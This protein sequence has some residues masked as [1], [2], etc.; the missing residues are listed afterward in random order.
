MGVVDYRSSVSQ[1]VSLSQPSLNQITVVL[2]VPTSKI[3]DKCCH[4]RIGS[5]RATATAAYTG[6]E[7]VQCRF[8]IAMYWIPCDHAK[9]AFLS[10]Y[11]CPCNL[12]IWSYQRFKLCF[13]GSWFAYIEAEL[14][15]MSSI[16]LH[17]NE[18]MPK[19]IMTMTVISLRS[20][21]RCF[22]VSL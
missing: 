12:H 3:N 19:I 5:N 14:R 18:R 9:E 7:F 6:F 8:G 22:C 20:C 10:Q 15:T 16:Q 2:R 11:S 13:M 17:C 4:L 1:S 21:R